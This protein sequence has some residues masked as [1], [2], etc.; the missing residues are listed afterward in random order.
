M[1][2]KLKEKKVYKLWKYNRGK[3]ILKSQCVK[4]GNIRRKHT[5]IQK[6]KKWNILT[7]KTKDVCAIGLFRTSVVN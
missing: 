7:M 2:T 5:V 3:R 4:T 6:G 1:P